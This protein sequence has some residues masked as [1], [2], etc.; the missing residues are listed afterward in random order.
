MAL[1]EPSHRDTVYNIENV[2][3]VVDALSAS[4]IQGATVDYVHTTYGDRFSITGGAGG[5]HC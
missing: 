1:D 4:Y 2:K 5:G 3:V